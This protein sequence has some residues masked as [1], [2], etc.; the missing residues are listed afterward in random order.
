MTRTYLAHDL[1]QTSDADRPD[2]VCDS[3]GEVVL[4]L[5]RRCGQAEADLERD[6]P[7]PTKKQTDVMYYYETA[8]AVGHWMPAKASS[9]PTV[10][11]DRISTANGQGPRVRRITEIDK[12]L[13]PL[14]L[15]DIQARLFA[16][17]DDAE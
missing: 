16:S 1:Y 7:G 15:S 17:D 8:D 10:K 6:C 11:N 12:A 14:S 9:R 13:W 4:D 3:N 5:C 2:T